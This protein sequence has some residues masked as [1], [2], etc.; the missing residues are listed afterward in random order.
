MSRKRRRQGLFLLAAGGAVAAFVFLGRK[1]DAEP[2]GPRRRARG[3]PDLP[4][5]AGGGAPPEPASRDRPGLPLAGGG[6]PQEPREPAPPG[7]PARPDLSNIESSE[8]AAGY[9]YQVRRGDTFGGTRRQS[10]AYQALY[11]AA[12]KAAEQMG[13]ADPEAFAKRIAGSGSNR[14]K[15]IDLIL[16]AGPNDLLYGTYGYG[17]KARPGPHGRSI[18]LR[19]LHPD[20]RS[21]IASGEQPLRNITMLSPDE[22]KAGKR[23]RAVD[24]EFSEGFEYLWLPPLEPTALYERGQIT[25]EGLTWPDGTSMMWPPPEVQALGFGV[26]D[27]PGLSMYGCGDGALVAQ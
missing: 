17:E 4:L 24:R 26:F 8:P 27:D 19:P 10:I 2:A 5:G 12:L 23:A 1:K 3:A 20:N 15:Y 18:T 13:D 21:L 11:A 25:T 6:L 14:V 7:A 22:R 16:C 9:Y